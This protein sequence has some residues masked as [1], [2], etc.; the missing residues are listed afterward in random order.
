MYLAEAMAK[1]KSVDVHI[2]PHTSVSVCLDDIFDDLSYPHYTL[3]EPTAKPPL[4]IF[5]APARTFAAG[6]PHPPTQ[7]PC[8]TIR[9]PQAPPLFGKRVPTF[10]IELHN[11]KAGFSSP[12]RGGSPAHTHPPV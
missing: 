3:A 7:N 6:R 10:A 8:T 9:A 12:C 11:E 2:T 1:E 5:E 4:G